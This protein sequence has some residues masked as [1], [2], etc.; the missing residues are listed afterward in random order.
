MVSYQPFISF[1]AKHWVQIRD[2]NLLAFDL[3]SRHYSFRKW[4]QR[5]GR[6]DAQTG[7]NCAVFRNESPV[8]SS[9]LILEAEQWAWNRWPQ[10][11]LFTF[12]NPKRI[13]STNPGYCFQR[14]GWRKCGRSTKG[15]IILEK[16]AQY[17]A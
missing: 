17:G 16:E 12:V 5:G 13:I 14:A 2:G 3:F 6:L 11:R 7:I 1:D 15:L 8:K 9:D 10:H 4:R